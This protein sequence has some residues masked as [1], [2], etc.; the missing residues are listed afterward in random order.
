MDITTVDTVLLGLIVLSF[1]VLNHRIWATHTASVQRDE[2][3]LKKADSWYKQLKL[4]EMI[5][6]ELSRHSA[7][8]HDADIVLSD[9][10]ALLER[11]VALENRVYEP[12]THVD[13]EDVRK[14]ASKYT[15]DT[16]EASTRVDTGD[17]D[18]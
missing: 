15:I 2:M 6:D 13:G 8:L 17:H 4:S 10:R 9:Y 3:L 14:P 7:E 18:E 5:V 16:S 1:G 12:V 11:V